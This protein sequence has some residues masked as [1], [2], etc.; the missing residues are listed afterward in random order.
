MRGYIAMDETIKDSLRQAILKSLP[1]LHELC[2]RGQHNELYLV[3]SK[4]E[5]GGWQGKYENRTCLFR[6]LWAAEKQL[7]EASSNFANL[8]FSKYADYGGHNLVGCDGLGSQ[9]LANDK[10]HILKSALEHLW[11]RHETFACQ[12][13]DVDSVINEFE[14]FIESPT[15]SIR[16]QAQLLNFTMPASVLHLPDN[17]IIR[18]LNEREISTLHG[19][20]LMGGGSSRHSMLG[21]IHQFVIEGEYKGAKVVAGK[22]TN[23]TPAQETANTQL[24]KAILCLRTFKEG[25]VGY[26][27][28]D[29]KF[30]KFCPLGLGSY[31]SNF[32]IVPPGAYSLLD[33][34]VR[35]LPDY[36]RNIF[37]LSES[38]LETACARLSDAEARFRPQ[39]QI[40]DAVVG[41]EAVLLAGL[42]KEDRR[43]ELKYR[44][45]MNYS[46]LYDSPKERWLAYKVAKDLY[47]HRSAIA[48]G[49][50]LDAKELRVG[51]EKLNLHETARRAKN[52]LRMVIKHFLPLSKAAP[53]KKLQ[54]W[55]QKY[56]GI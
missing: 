25:F 56:F 20:P 17:L 1:V 30:V 35:A 33:E 9:Q 46:T 43:S 45:S 26:Q 14:E 12:V 28:V 32:K 15:M 27:W 5:N 19:G 31:G 3:W 4:T 38:A 41:M 6:V 13:S 42:G 50:E 24:D 8:F 54:F 29:L 36:A 16:F 49:G 7:A 18:K 51:E 44:F 47:D 37:T 23:M 11:N 10:S 55:E 22:F 39:D 2:L 40:L 34:E 21:L 52:T 53:Y 48:H